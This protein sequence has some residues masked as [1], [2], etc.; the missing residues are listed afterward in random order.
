MPPSRDYAIARFASMT[1]EELRRVVTDEREDW[2]PYALELAEEELTRRQEAALSTPYREAAAI[3]L[4]QG[5][6]GLAAPVW[7]SGKVV[8]ADTWSALLGMSAIGNVV[9]AMVLDGGRQAIGR[10]IFLGAF[11]LA[12][13]IGLRRRSTLAWY[14]NWLPIAAPLIMG[15]ARAD[16]FAFLVG[17]ALTIPNGHYFL[18]HRAL[19][20]LAP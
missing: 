10:A 3:D 5:M 18:K 6:G 11:V 16:A 17:L 7:G 13:A 19:F 1:D 8:W 14:A 12:L 2:L 20:G 9:A 4:P 15:L